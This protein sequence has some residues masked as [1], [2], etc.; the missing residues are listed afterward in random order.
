MARIYRTFAPAAALLAA[1]MATGRTPVAIEFMDRPAILA[2]EKFTGAGYPLAKLAERLKRFA[3][4]NE[5]QVYLEPGEAAITKSTTLEV[6]V[7]DTLNNGKN[8]A[9]VDSSI[10]DHMLDVL[11]YR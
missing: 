8:L 1:I 6:T 7:L 3:G 10:E 5:V 9:I 2:C 11:I 4:Q